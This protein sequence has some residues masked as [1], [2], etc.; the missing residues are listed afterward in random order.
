MLHTVNGRQRQ[1]DLCEFKGCLVYTGSFRS[2]RSKPDSKRKK[3]K[4]RKRRRKGEE[5]YNK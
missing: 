1:A 5:K 2:V 3:K 4:G